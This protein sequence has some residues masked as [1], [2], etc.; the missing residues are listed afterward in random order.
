MTPSASIVAVAATTENVLDGNGRR[1]TIRRLTALDRLRLFKAAGPALAQNQPW[2]GMALIACS[3]AAIDN[4]PIPSPSNELQIEAMIGR[5]GDT[6]ARGD[7]AGAGAICGNHYS[8]DGRHG[9]KLSRHP[10]LI[11]CLYLVRNGVPFDVAF[12]LPTDERMAF[13]VALGSLDGR[14]FDWRTLRC[15]VESDR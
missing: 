14:T 7:C 15:V 12:S 1:L 6:G 10:D 9:G 2:L 3:V 13:V 4:V 5:L 8:R 11:D